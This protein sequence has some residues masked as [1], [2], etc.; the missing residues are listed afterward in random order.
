MADLSTSSEGFLPCDVNLVG[1]APIFT[2]WQI[3]GLTEGNM[4]GCSPW[5]ATT[6]SSTT[7]YVYG[8]N[9]LGETVFNG[10]RL[11]GSGAGDISVGGHHVSGSVYWDGTISNDLFTI[12]YEESSSSSQ[13]SS[14]SSSSKS[15]SSSISSSVSSQ[16]STS[17][18]VEGLIFQFAGEK[19]SLPSLE[20]DIVNKDSLRNDMLIPN[21]NRYENFL[22][23]IDDDRFR[24]DIYENP[25]IW[26]FRSIHSEEKTAN[27]IVLTGER[28]G[29][30][31][32][33]LGHG[34]GYTRYSGE[35][36]LVFS[37]SKLELTLFNLL[38]G[39]NKTLSFSDFISE[40]DDD[41]RYIL[42]QIPEVDDAA[43]TFFTSNGYHG[44]YVLRI[45]EV[46]EL[47]WDA[48]FSNPVLID[49]ETSTIYND[50]FLQVISVWWKQILQDV[51]ISDPI[52]NSVFLE[53]A[54]SLI[55]PVLTT[56]G[57]SVT[58]IFDLKTRFPNYLRQIGSEFFSLSDEAKE[59]I[60]RD[61][62]LGILATQ[63][64]ESPADNEGSPLIGIGIGESNLTVD[65]NPI[66]KHPAITEE[67]YSFDSQGTGRLFGLDGTYAAYDLH[68]V[69]NDL[70]GDHT[71]TDIR[72]KDPL[73][74]IYVDKKND[75]ENN[76]S[77]VLSGV[78]DS[79]IIPV[80]VSSDRQPWMINVDRSP[81]QIKNLDV[82][83]G[84]PSADPNARLATL[85]LYRNY[86]L[87][88]WGFNEKFNDDH[89][90][91]SIPDYTDK[92]H[93]LFPIG[94]SK[95]WAIENSDATNDFTNYKHSGLFYYQPPSG[96]Y[97]DM[98]S[99][100]SINN[101][102]LFFYKNYMLAF[103]IYPLIDDNVLDNEKVIW[104]DYQ[105]HLFAT[106]KTV[107][108]KIQFCFRFVETL[109]QSS[110]SSIS[111][112]SS[113]STSSLGITS[114]SISSSSTSSSTLILTTSSSMSSST[115]SSQSSTSSSS[116]SSLSSESSSSSSSTSSSSQ[117][118]ESSSAS[119]T[120]S[121]SASSG[122]SESS[123]SSSS[124]STEQN[125][126]CAGFSTF[127]QGLSDFGIA[128]P[129]YYVE[130]EIYDGTLLPIDPK[131]VVHG[132]F[133]DMQAKSEAVAKS[134]LDCGNLEE[135]SS[136][137][138]SAPP[139]DYLTVRRSQ[140]HEA[141]MF[142]KDSG[143]APAINKIAG[144]E[145]HNS[146][147]KSY[148]YST[149]G[150]I[151][152]VNI[153]TFFDDTYLQVIWDE[154]SA[155]TIDIYIQWEDAADISTSS[156]SFSESSI[157]NISSI[158]S[159]TSSSSI[160]STS[161]VSSSSQTSGSTLSTLSSESSLS[162]LSTDSSN[163][164]SESS[165]SSQTSHSST[166]SL[167][168][169]SSSSFSSGSSSTVSPSSES[170]SLSSSSQSSQ[171][172]SSLTISSSSISS[173]S[174]SSPSSSS[175]PSSTSFSESS[176]SSLSSSSESS[177]SSSSSSSMSSTSSSSS[178]IERNTYEVCSPL[179]DRDKLY[180][181]VGSITH[182][183]ILRVDVAETTGNTWSPS[184]VGEITNPD[185][186][187]V[188]KG[189]NNNI[190]IGDDPNDMV[191]DSVGANMFID[192]VSVWRD[193]P[194]INNDILKDVVLAY[195]NR[196]YFQKNDKRW[197]YV[198]PVE[199]EDLVNSDGI[200]IS[201]DTKH[202]NAVMQS[203]SLGTDVNEKNYYKY[204]DENGIIRELFFP[205]SLF[206]VSS[207]G[208]VIETI[209]GI[210]E[211]NGEIAEF[212]K[213]SIPALRDN[214]IPILNN[215]KAKQRDDGTGL[216]DIVFDYLSY[217]ENVVA[218]VSLSISNDL[219]ESFGITAESLNGDI[220]WGV[221]PGTNRRIVWTP[222]E[223][224]TDANGN[225]FVFKVTLVDT[226]G[227][228]VEDETGAITIDTYFGDP[229][230]QETRSNGDLE[231]IFVTVPGEEIDKSY[232]YTG[233]DIKST[234]KIAEDIEYVAWSSSS[235]L[236]IASSQSSE[237]SSISSSSVSS[238]SS[239]KSSLGF[240]S[241]SST[242]A[243]RIF[244]KNTGEDIIPGGPC[245]NG[246]DS[247]WLLDDGTPAP[248]EHS[249]WHASWCQT[250]ETSGW[251][252]HDCNSAQ[253]VISQHT[254]YDYHLRVWIGEEVDLDIT[255]FGG[256]FL[257]DNEVVDV[258]VN[259]TS[260]GINGKRLDCDG[261]TYFN[262]T[263]YVSQGSNL[264]TFRTLNYKPH[265]PANHNPTGLRVEWIIDVDLSSVSS[266][267]TNSSTEILDS[268][269]S[270]SSMSL[271]SGSTSLAGCTLTLA[272]QTISG[273]SVITASQDSFVGYE[274]WHIFDQ[275]D[276]TE[277]RVNFSY[278]WSGIFEETHWIE[279][280]ALYP[281]YAESYR[282]HAQ[283][284]SGVVSGHG[285]PCYPLNYNVYGSNN[286]SSWTLLDNYTIGE[287]DLI[288]REFSSGVSYR[289][290]RLE[291]T[292]WNMTSSGTPMS[293]IQKFD[294]CENGA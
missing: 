66:P 232:I 194:S 39:I 171:S 64:A 88:F 28:I 239:S 201:F 180:S 253:V 164:S 36:K 60:I 11:I 47:Y 222:H 283:Q 224:L 30:H 272:K 223:D 154:S 181:F 72:S 233:V 6:Y 173:S 131:E 274:P 275:E 184:W 78:E 207:N 178:S 4:P 3:V 234:S 231:D 2:N 206:T 89:Y 146:K 22:R 107:G 209:V 269:I 59:T 102:D 99:L 128:Y 254:E 31:I 161:S 152:T 282:I 103:Y 226:N 100:S 221:V 183:G 15:S 79:T 211:A 189:K 258:V 276:D 124:V 210:L 94:N 278:D 23:S 118:T 125:D 261:W 196:V 187:Y 121:S 85:N 139:N 123:T 12:A 216:V 101:D 106:Y 160:V 228:S 32:N 114:S 219:G 218:T 293:V 195:A 70:T 208:N 188:Y 249:P 51:D 277:W 165:L 71:Q 37:K 143:P 145:F 190:V 74:A 212:H 256:R 168:S 137:K 220:G 202:P 280:D 33:L 21:N 42:W 217:H 97:T 227:N 174:L 250:D 86:M 149:T 38:T 116:I 246:F 290:Y 129:V 76:L 48:D 263:N 138:T 248:M 52:S 192:E 96:I 44:L 83:L 286:G 257:V 215:V 18:E 46:C 230:E 163:S 271:S 7:Q 13:T 176:T 35:N 242:E 113:S 159:I 279:I 68:D 14:L 140:I 87:G 77:L 172:L 110:M 241:S 26:G 251:I 132:T 141:H 53:D 268:S 162:S 65:E 58:E 127:M 262:I 104:A 191:K 120:S 93:T 200:N 157:S 10:S 81:D 25:S 185:G 75:N 84:D 117:S 291:I 142:I 90:F 203:V 288:E 267:S 270:S 292:S 43:K 112:A 133:H 147:I 24:G 115:S 255:D 169:L 91:T 16:S 45:R 95:V 148:N 108:D 287:N 155:G 243:H 73:Q 284:P 20:L 199:I 265:S 259:G 158:S 225:K 61:Y 166:S 177:Q 170:S 197:N 19:I 92:G 5:I 238:V 214:L 80:E 247:G 273:P 122:S 237:S 281:E 57:L 167:S 285:T 240:T 198:N 245:G 55:A 175:S 130:Q 136:W 34:V 260:T 186:F 69:L 8:I 134:G 151:G 109:E 289:Y 266:M 179:L 9:T 54:D 156:V 105:N 98:P 144:L 29:I 50:S 229:S 150:G 205:K 235:S 204:I 49:G 41:G 67:F 153:S 27:A 264:I 135:D 63:I 111:S 294:L 182:T 244:F 126:S 236:A 252:A 56:D 213:T 40:P 119:S 82:F 1:G 62:C 193:L 17:S